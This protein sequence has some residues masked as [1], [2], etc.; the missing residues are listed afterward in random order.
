MEAVLRGAAGSAT[1]PR[2]RQVMVVDHA[3]DHAL[4]ALDGPL[5]ELG[6][7]GGVDLGPVE[8]QVAAVVP[9]EVLLFF[10]V[11]RA[12]GAAGGRAAA[13]A[14]AVGAARHGGAA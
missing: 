6:A 8:G 1:A 14:V 3:V 2:L 5:G 12:G 10:R 11:R 9:H 7:V 13:V 4:E